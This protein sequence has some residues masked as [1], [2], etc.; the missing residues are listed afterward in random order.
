M[1]HSYQGHLCLFSFDLTP[2]SLLHGIGA[3]GS[4]RFKKQGQICKV[5][6]T[7]ANMRLELKTRAE[8]Q[9]A[10]FLSNNTGEVCA[11]SL[12]TE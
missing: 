10:L 2:L 3:S 8:M 12:K 1:D 7:G 9:L 11:I 6:K 4:F 5:K